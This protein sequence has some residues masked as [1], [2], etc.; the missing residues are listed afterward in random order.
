MFYLH[1][2]KTVYAR[3]LDW[4][5]TVNG[6]CSRGSRDGACSPDGLIDGRRQFRLSTSHVRHVRMGNS[7]VIREDSGTK[8]VSTGYNESVLARVVDSTM[9]V[10][11]CVLAMHCTWCESKPDKLHSV[12]GSETVNRQPSHSIRTPT[13]FFLRSS[14]PLFRDW[15]GLLEEGGKKKAFFVVQRM[16]GHL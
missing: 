14:Y 10:P 15:L 3:R 7:C 13:I 16:I 11:E 12:A 2:V 5:A 4:S 9:R 1:F 6:A 8:W